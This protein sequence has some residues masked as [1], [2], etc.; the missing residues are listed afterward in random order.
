VS[1]VIYDPDKRTARWEGED[2]PLGS[3]GSFLVERHV[4]QDLVEQGVEWLEVHGPRSMRRCNIITARRHAA[5]V[6]TFDPRSQQI[7]D[8]LVEIPWR[9]WAR[10]EHE[11]PTPAAGAHEDPEESKGPRRR[12]GV[13]EDQEMML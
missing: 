5:R 4:M 13:N 11:R 12:R 10:T 6:S 9:V 1:G 7:S 2:V 8:R 3:D